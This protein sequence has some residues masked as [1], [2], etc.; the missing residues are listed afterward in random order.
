MLSSTTMKM[1]LHVTQYVGFF[2]AQITNTTLLLL[3]FTRAKRLFGS[4]RHVMAVFAFY[5][6]VYTWIEVITQ[7]IMHIQGSMFI[8]MMD[9]PIQFSID[10]GNKITCL[11][12]GS[13]ALCIALLGAQFFYRYMAVCKPDKLRLIEGRCLGLL[14]LPC[15]VVFVLWTSCVYFGM[16]NTQDKRDF[17]RVKIMST[18]DEDL[19][20]KSFIAAMYWTYGQNQ[21]RQFRFLDIMGLSGCTVLIV[22]CFLTI[23]F[24]ALQVYWKMKDAE[25][26]MSAKTKELNRQLFV[27]LIFQTALPF[28]MMYSPVGLILTLPIF[29]LDIGRM[30]NFCGASAGTYPALEP[31]IAILFIRDFRRTVLCQRT[32]KCR[33][34]GINTFSQFSNSRTNENTPSVFH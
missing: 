7:P 19:F 28:I 32:K 10:V 29:E 24:C 15:I 30:M 21:E 6:L 12:C 20:K 31:L 27:T 18:Y 34:S 9:G 2:G 25:N 8:V 22:L 23:V 14:F 11:Y 1:I 13:F 26:I 16:A 17:M 4:Y 33:I 5:S 3:L